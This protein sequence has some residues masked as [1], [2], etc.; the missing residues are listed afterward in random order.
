MFVIR[1][2]F[3]CKPGQSKNLIEKFKKAMPMMEGI[4]QRVLVDEVATFWT[5]VIETETEDL[6]AFEKLLRE[7]SSNQQVMDAMA[8]YMD[9][10]DSGYR[11]IYR[12]VS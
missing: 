9:H 4:K 2:V 6:A 12:A 5:V 10:V 1:N 7:R 8:G 3:K 11:E